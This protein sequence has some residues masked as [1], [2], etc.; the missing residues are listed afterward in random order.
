MAWLFTTLYMSHLGDGIVRRVVVSFFDTFGVG[1]R[2]QLWSYSLEELA[3]PYRSMC[4]GGGRVRVRGNGSTS[5]RLLSFV[6]VFQSC[7]VCS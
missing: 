1:L 4:W 5:M 7:S 3:Y 2:G 6:I